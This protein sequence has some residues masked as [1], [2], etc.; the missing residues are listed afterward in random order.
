MLHNN[1]LIHSCLACN[2][3]SFM[4]VYST[5]ILTWQLSLLLC[6]LCLLSRWAAGCLSEDIA[7][8]LFHI[9]RM[10]LQL[11]QREKTMFQGLFH[12]ILEWS[13]SYWLNQ[14]CE[15]EW[16]DPGL[17]LSNTCPATR[18]NLLSWIRFSFSR[19]RLICAC[20]VSYFIFSQS[21]LQI[22]L[23]WSFR[24]NFSCS[25][26]SNNNLFCCSQEKLQSWRRKTRQTN[27]YHHLPY[28]Q[29]KL[30]FLTYLLLE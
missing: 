19:S 21:Q 2:V 15:G 4:E 3:Q 25:I 17:S 22:R 18:V 16:L 30:S 10:V 12:W 27:K 5:N 11:F 9:F 26:W 20:S 8:C 6:W 29:S 24:Q 13:A 7:T 28:L 23:L 1:W 14:K